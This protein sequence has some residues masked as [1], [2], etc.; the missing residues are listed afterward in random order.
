MAFVNP[1]ALSHF[2]TVAD[3]LKIH[4]REYN[5]PARETWPVVCLP[6]LARTAMDF[7]RIADGLYALAQKKE[8]A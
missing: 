7:D 1:D 2:I 3:G 6:G 4:A 5:S 8:G